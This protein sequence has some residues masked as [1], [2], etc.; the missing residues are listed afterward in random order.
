M[1][2]RPL[3]CAASFER[4]SP[5]AAG[6]RKSWSG[7]ELVVGSLVAAASFGRSLLRRPEMAL[8]SPSHAQS[9]PNTSSRTLRRRSFPVS[10]NGKASTITIE[11]GVLEVLR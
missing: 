6:D 3:G 7:D 10:V 4:A 11:S 5:A 9:W 1:L 8:P 2:L